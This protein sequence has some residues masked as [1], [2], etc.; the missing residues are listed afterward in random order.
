[1]PRPHCLLRC[2]VYV[3]L[4]VQSAWRQ[5]RKKSATPII[6][7]P[8]LTSVA[9]TA[10]PGFH[11]DFIGLCRLDSAEVHIMSKQTDE[12]DGEAVKE[13]ALP[14]KDI[15]DFTKAVE[16]RIGKQNYDDWRLI[17]RIYKKAADAA[18]AECG[19]ESSRH[20][21]TYKKAFSRI[22][23]VLPPIAANESTC[24]KYRAALLNI[25]YAPK[26][27]AWYA[28]QDL[29]INNPY[30]LW[31]AFRDDTKPKSE[32][33]S[34]GGKKP[35]RVIKHQR[36]ITQLEESYAAKVG[37]MEDE[38]TALRAQNKVLDSAQG[39]WQLLWNQYGRDLDTFVSEMITFL[40]GKG[41]SLSNIKGVL[42]RHQTETT[43]DAA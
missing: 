18:L 22:I 23:A 6:G 40:G 36:E 29:R 20:S 37:A 24:E 42:R 2:S 28:K 27:D 26:F 32:T 17:G 12:D 33:E 31:H 21:P 19:P 41:Y 43:G 39:E 9:I 8:P 34:S 7:I 15:A 30:D 1:M 16:R 35:Q 38:I 5:T 4:E 11:A 14:K 25:E 3:C 10:T 13:Y